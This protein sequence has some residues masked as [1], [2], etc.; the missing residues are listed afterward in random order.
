[1]IHLGRRTAVLCPC[2]WCRQPVGHTRI[3]ITRW[4]GAGPRCREEPLSP[5]PPGHSR[6]S[7]G[8]LAGGALR[9][10]SPLPARRADTPRARRGGRQDPADDRPSA[11]PTPPTPARLR[12]PRG[13]TSSAVALVTS[14]KALSKVI[15]AP[16]PAGPGCRRHRHRRGVT[17]PSSRD[18][19]RPDGDH[20][21]A[22]QLL[23]VGARRAEVSGDRRQRQAQGG[24]PAGC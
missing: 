18:E 15:T 1:M 8:R 9:R 23:Q 10:R 7:V 6:S 19:Q 14:A 16:A 13:R 17:Q 20:V 11:I 2:P 22:H 4:H 12:R 3:C 24:R 21:A 5:G